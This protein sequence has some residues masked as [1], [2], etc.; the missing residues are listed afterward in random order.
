MRGG[1]GRCGKTRLA[2]LIMAIEF[3]QLAVVLNDLISANHSGCEKA[4][5]QIKPH[6]GALFAKLSFART[7]NPF[8][9]TSNFG[10]QSQYFTRT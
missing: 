5:H 7:G 1:R 10:I 6:S 9:F 8:P 2:L 4:Q 3:I